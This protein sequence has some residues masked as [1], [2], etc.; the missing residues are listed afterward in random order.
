[1]NRLTVISYYKWKILFWIILFSLIVTAFIYGPEYGIDQKFVVFTTVVLGIFTQVFAGI[2]SLVA[3]IPFFGPF[4]IKV[5]SIPIFYI[6][7]AV[8][9]IVSGVAIKKGYVN[10][11]SKSRTVTLALLIG[12][13]IGYILGNVIPLE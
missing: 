12:I 11:L 13:I 1:M 5:I 7:N 2:T 4:I 6:L 3:L 8:G 9:W 10:E